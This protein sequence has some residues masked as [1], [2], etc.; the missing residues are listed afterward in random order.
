MIKFPKFCDVLWYYYLE[1]PMLKKLKVSTPYLSS[2]VQ[3]APGKQLTSPASN[4]V[5]TYRAES[6]S[7]DTWQDKA[8]HVHTSASL[9][10]PLHISLTDE[11]CMMSSGLR[12]SSSHVCQYIRRGLGI[13]LITSHRGSQELVSS[14]KIYWT[15]SR[16]VSDNYQS[17]FESQIW[18]NYRVNEMKRSRTGVG[19]AKCRD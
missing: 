14:L 15:R 10:G 11:P 19:L 6:C 2:S 1:E 8:S 12:V 5:N 17:A 7:R 4:H 13:F 9:P 16:E 18:F 3:W